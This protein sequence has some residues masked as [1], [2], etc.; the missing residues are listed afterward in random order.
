MENLDHEPTQYGVKG[1]KYKET[2]RDRDKTP[3]YEKYKI[4]ESLSSNSGRNEWAV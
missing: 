3:N 1:S 2:K 4:D